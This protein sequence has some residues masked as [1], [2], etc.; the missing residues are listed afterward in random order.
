M[1]DQEIAVEAATNALFDFQVIWS[2][3]RRLLCA[4][5]A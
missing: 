5:D 2:A 3:F 4:L 1:R